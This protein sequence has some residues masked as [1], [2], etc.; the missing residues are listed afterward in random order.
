MTEEGDIQLHEAQQRRKRKKSAFTSG[1]KTKGLQAERPA[2]ATPLL[3]LPVNNAKPVPAAGPCSYV[4]AVCTVCQRSVDDIIA[5][6]LP[7]CNA[8]ESA[9]QTCTSATR[10]LYNRLVVDT[11][12][13]CDK[14]GARL[15]RITCCCD[16]INQNIPR[17]L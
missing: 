13:T 3:L 9:S 4:S 10:Y 5:S 16:V 7:G 17:S 11:D 2:W 8:D 15:I 1:W 6:R 14:A 12:S